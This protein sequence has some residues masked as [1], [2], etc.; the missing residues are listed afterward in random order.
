[1]TRKQV[2]NL[3]KDTLGLFVPWNF[4]LGCQDPYIWEE[5]FAS[6]TEARAFAAQVLISEKLLGTNK[7]DH[8][9]DLAKLGRWL[10]NPGRRKRDNHLDGDENLYRWMCRRIVREMEQ[11]DVDSLFAKYHKNREIAINNLMNEGMV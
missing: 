11:M 6:I 7:K 8:I 5:P 10:P 3:R 9:E 4:D 1:M 2:S